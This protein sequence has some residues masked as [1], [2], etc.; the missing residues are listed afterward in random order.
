MSQSQKIA[1]HKKELDAKT[2]ELFD[3]IEQLSPEQLD[4]KPAPDSWSIRQVAHHLLTAEGN[5][6]RAARKQ[7][8][9]SKP[10]LKDRFGHF[11][12]RLV[13][14]LGIKVK[15]P[16]GLAPPEDERLAVEEIRERWGKNRLE[17][18]ELIAAVPEAE[19]GGTFF[20]HPFA[21]P[22]DYV[23][24]VEFMGQH[25]THHLR[26]IGRIEESPGYPAKDPPANA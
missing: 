6:L 11:M 17:I 7:Q 20:R 23:Q 14:R 18:E 22:L 15:A 2:A 10:K 19:L 24:G 26:Q 12:V 9:T 16:E 21:G 25:I 8:G 5:I 4:F 3:K 1:L 13:L